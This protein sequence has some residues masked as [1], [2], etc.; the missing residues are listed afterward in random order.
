MS[1]TLFS[2]LPRIKL[3]R[4]SVHNFNI[5][6]TFTLSYVVLLHQCN[7]CN[8]IF[9]DCLQIILENSH[10]LPHLLVSGV[11]LT[12][13]PKHNFFYYS[14]NNGLDTSVCPIC[15]IWFKMLRLG[16]LPPSCYQSPSRLLELG[17]GV[18]S[19]QAPNRREQGGHA[20]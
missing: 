6:A 12:T 14:F 9:V 3:S 18:P 4:Q 15:K 5:H 13:Y 16:F 7:C 8:V 1:L 17:L 10:P 2:A 11:V 20:T 19:R